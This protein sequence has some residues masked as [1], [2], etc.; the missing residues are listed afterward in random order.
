MGVGFNL[1]VH[2]ENNIEPLT[3][4]K[5]LEL[6]VKVQHHPNNLEIPKRFQQKRDR[7]LQRPQI[8]GV[9]KVL[10]R[11]CVAQAFLKA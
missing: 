3:S 4:E 11:S 1:T 10:R 7:P 6:L 8:E 5:V 2:I 9:P